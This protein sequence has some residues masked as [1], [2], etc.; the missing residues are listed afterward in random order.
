M[1]VP[2]DDWTI[3]G[4]GSDAKLIVQN[5]G[6]SRIAWVIAA[7]KPANDPEAIALDGD[8]HGIFNPGHE[9][10]TLT[11]LDTDE[12][13]LYVRSLGSKHGKLYVYDPAA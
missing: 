13:N 7:A 9:P 4:Q 10:V 5:V 12:T 2:E 3:V 11:G 6:V 1:D 8:G